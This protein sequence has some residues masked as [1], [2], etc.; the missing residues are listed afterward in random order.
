MA[1]FTIFETIGGWISRCAETEPSELTQP[2]TGAGPDWKQAGPSRHEEL[3]AVLQLTL[4]IGAVLGLPQTACNV[5][6]KA[7]IAIGVEILSA[8]SNTEC[9]GQEDESMR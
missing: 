5:G 8:T 1:V 2:R 3:V 4:I 7:T 9:H 6:R